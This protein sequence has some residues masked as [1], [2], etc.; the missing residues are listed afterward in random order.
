VGDAIRADRRSL[1]DLAGRIAA[2]IDQV[3]SYSELIGLYASDALVGPETV[4]YASDI[5]DRL[6]A[7]SRDVFSVEIAASSEEIRDCFIGAEADFG[8]DGFPD[9]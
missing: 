8:Q 1:I 6:A 4:A 7:V 3:G 2:E 9:G 5:S